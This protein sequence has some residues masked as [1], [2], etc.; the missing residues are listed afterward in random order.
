MYSLTLEK[1]SLARGELLIP[2]PRPFPFTQTVITR[3]RAECNCVW[4]NFAIN[5][6]GL[7]G[8]NIT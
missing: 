4:A 5:G 7:V 8:L 6:E 3:A 2:G 1:K